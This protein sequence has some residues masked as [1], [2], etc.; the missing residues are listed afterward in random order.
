MEQLTGE[1]HEPDNLFKVACGLSKYLPLSLLVLTKSEM[2]RFLC[3]QKNHRCCCPQ[4]QIFALNILKGL[5]SLY[6]A[7]IITVWSVIFKNFNDVVRS[8][9]VAVY[10][11]LLG[12]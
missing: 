1:I 5:L 12:L 4:H 8:V 9:S 6:T 11:Y 10:W 2:S 3:A 7:I